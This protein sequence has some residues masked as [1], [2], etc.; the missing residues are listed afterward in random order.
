MSL[1]SR[2]Q[3]IKSSLL[4]TTAMFLPGCWPNKNRVSDRLLVS[5]CTGFDGEHYVAAITDAGE[6][7]TQIKLPARAHECLALP[8]KPGRALVIARRPGDFLLEVDFI[9]GQIVNQVS[10]EPGY[11][12]YGHGCLLPGG[13]YIC[14]SENNYDRGAGRLVLRE[15]SSLKVVEALDSGGIGPH[16]IKVMPDETT[17]VIAN[18]GILTHPEQ[19]RKKLNLDSMRPNLAYMSLTDGQILDRFEL[20]NHRL[21]IRHLDVCEKGKV[22]AGLQYQGPKTDIN[23]LL[24]SHQ[25][26]S[27]LS[28]FKGDEDT[29]LAMAQ[30]VASL[31]IDSSSDLVA[32]SCPKANLVTLWQL[33]TGKF[34]ARHKIRD[35][36]GLTLSER[37]VW[38]SN[39]KGGMF[40][41]NGKHK[42]SKFQHPTLRWDNHL[43]QI[44]TV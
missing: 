18:G 34:L 25:G 31:C 44:H 15:R 37:G 5:A 9:T 27:Q 21:S 10:S 29:W 11:H 39:G 17:L 23:P 30:Y 40:E 12:F 38:V 42:T 19:P 36:A 33:S 4:L 13:E 14:T 32:A 43:T 26:E 3:F 1:T 24:I 20:A 7:V 2:R 16:Q 6:L 28:P 35:G 22:V 41:V 8:D